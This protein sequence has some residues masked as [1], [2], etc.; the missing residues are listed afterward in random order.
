MLKSQI[1]VW[2]G[3][4]ASSLCLP[5]YLEERLPAGQLPEVT[6]SGLDGSLDGG[7]CPPQQHVM[8]TQGPPKSP[9]IADSLYALSNQRVQRE[10]GL[11][12][13]EEK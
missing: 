6:A 2:L 4:K 13:E 9:T 10:D 7:V 8:V 12:G 5:E 1:Q 3:T 11:F